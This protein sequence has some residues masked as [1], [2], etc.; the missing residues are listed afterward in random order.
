[1]R[2]DKHHDS[3]RFENGKIVEAWSLTD[4]FGLLRQMGALK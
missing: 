4:F 2:G 1:M 3:R